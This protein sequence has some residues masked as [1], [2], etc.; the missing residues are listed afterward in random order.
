M[1]KE[2]GMMTEGQV[3]FLLIHQALQHSYQHL[4]LSDDEISPST[5]REFQQAQEDLKSALS[6]AAAIDKKYLSYRRTM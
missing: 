5:L 4:L 6:F 2:D 3:D 1:E